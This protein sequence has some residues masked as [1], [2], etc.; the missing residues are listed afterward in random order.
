M[1]QNNYFVKNIEFEPTLQTEFIDVAECGN[2]CF[3]LFGNT[4]F[5]NAS[6]GVFYRMDNSGKIYWEKGLGGNTSIKFT[7]VKQTDNNSI[8]VAGCN[9][10]KYSIELLRLNNDGNLL[11]ESEFTPQ[12]LD[13]HSITPATII[14]T[15]SN[16]FVISGRLT[17]NNQHDA[18]ITQYYPVSGKSKSI[19]LGKI[20]ANDAIVSSVNQGN[21]L[22]FAGNTWQ[23]NSNSAWIV[24]ADLQCNIKRRSTLEKDIKAVAIKKLSGHELVVVCNHTKK[25]Y[26]IVL[27]LDTALN[28]VKSIAFNNM[29]GVKA[30]NIS[31]NTDSTYILYGNITNKGEKKSDAFILQSDKHGNVQWMRKFGTKQETENCLAINRKQNQLIAVCTGQRKWLV[32]K[33]NS[34]AYIPY[35]NNEKVQ[36]EVNNIVY[37]DI[38]NRY[39]HSINAVIPYSDSLFL[40][41][42]SISD[43]ETDKKNIFLFTANKSNKI[44]WAKELTL[45]NSEEAI[46][47]SKSD[48]GFVILAQTTPKHHFS[49]TIIYKFN[50][51]GDTLWSKR[52][53]SQNISFKKIESTLN[54]YIIA[55][56][57]N[58]SAS[59]DNIEMVVIALNKKG[60]LMW[61][62]NIGVNGYWEYLSDLKK[63]SEG[64]IVCGHTT[65]TGRKNSE[66]VVAKIDKNGDLLWRKTFE[67]GRSAKAKAV[68]CDS[69]GNIY[70]AGTVEMTKEANENV[71]LMKLDN[72]AEKLWS[73]NY[74]IYRNDH[75]ET[76]AIDKNNSI[77]VAGNTG[78]RNDLL[79]ES[80]GYVLKTS[81]NGQKKY[82]KIYGD[83]YGITKITDFYTDNSNN[84]YAFGYA[85]FGW[86][87]QNSIAVHCSDKQMLPPAIA[88]ATAQTPSK[89][90]ITWL[91]SKTDFTLEY[92]TSP[93]FTNPVVF[94][95]KKNK[96]KVIIDDLSPATR[97]YIRLTT[98]HSYLKHTTAAVTVK[99]PAYPDENIMLTKTQTKQQL[100]LQW[101]TTLDSTLR[102][103]LQRATSAGFE[104]VVQIS[105]QGIKQYT[106]NNTNGQR[107]Y[108]RLKT[109]A[110]N[111]IY[112]SNIVDAKLEFVLNPPYGI[113]QLFASQESFV[114]C[115]HDKS[116]NEEGFV[117]HR[118]ENHLFENYDEFTVDKNDTI[119]TD[120]QINNKS[121][122]YKVA[123]YSS[124]S[125][126]AFT[127]AIKVEASDNELET[128]QTRHKI[129]A[130][131]FP[132]PSKSHTMIQYSMGNQKS[133]VLTLYDI[134]SNEIKKVTLNEPSGKVSLNT[135]QLTPGIYFYNITS[136]NKNITLDKLLIIK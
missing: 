93:E 44:L 92:D 54:G 72:N 29:E 131:V 71:L 21:N 57:A 47:V 108:Y 28:V 35:N 124:N 36:L 43:S 73:K 38:K 31:F 110:N 6:T 70:I 64:I 4:V 80:Y 5:D 136:T 50:A 100:K 114:I 97:Y 117:I 46:A 83:M 107:Y 14:K 25:Q 128:T 119:F 101:R 52:Y 58:R 81:I 75:V 109:R 3:F 10:D 85:A 122:Y 74:H 116:E 22:F 98:K 40:A 112:Y 132:N 113:E 30:N 11:W 129:F 17:N 39:N 45:S 102:Y 9:L 63:T 84:I 19:R 79:I 115:W 126:S 89:I 24:I 67:E 91:D 68:E 59:E 78:L 12:G 13:Y 48:N 26:P 56:T 34:T 60:E 8:Y 106:E 125:T 123:A 133:G 7:T 95:V 16:E 96:N 135:S 130:H 49:N 65:K 15:D 20:T 88:A 23:N 111:K 42:G 37:F 99:T 66:I 27:F 53:Q 69:N 118:S 41:T 1:A 76:I 82:V 33:T 90:E 127:P 94:P 134:N 18:F 62:T 2:N 55:G 77:I 87:Q 105:L 121:Y 103:E 86:N 120:Y 61:E 104:E 51:L 32:M